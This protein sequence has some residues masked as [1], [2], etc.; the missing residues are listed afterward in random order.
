ADSPRSVKR[1]ASLAVAGNRGPYRGRSARWAVYPFPPW[2]PRRVDPTARVEVGHP[3]TA[4]AAPFRAVNPAND[5]SDSAIPECPGWRVRRRPRG[6][7]E[8][9]AELR[10]EIRHGHELTGRRQHADIV[11]VDVP[12]GF[13]DT[14]TGS[15]PLSGY[16]H[17]LA[18]RHCRTENGMVMYA[19]LPGRP[20]A[21]CAIEWNSE[22]AVHRAARGSRQRRTPHEH[23]GGRRNPL[24]P[25]GRRPSARGAVRARPVG[26]PA[27][28]YTRP[29][30][31]L[32]S[33][34]RHGTRG[35]C[36]YLPTVTSPGRPIRRSRSR[37]D[38]GR[39]VEGCVCHGR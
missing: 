24:R 30:V 4:G 15:L 8:C 19:G 13:I 27:W 3:V 32:E 25:G 34:N 23:R 29:T 20:A 37:V 9:A 31:R 6:L 10:V 1:G 17:V 22:S 28:W 2:C 33:L 39:G 38:R 7:A 16:G 35:R 21:V 36:C 18:Y 5:A 26:I 11:T 12:V 14:E